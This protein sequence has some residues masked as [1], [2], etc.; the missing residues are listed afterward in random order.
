MISVGKHLRA[1]VGKVALG[2]LRET[3]G[4]SCFG[5]I[6]ALGIGL[7]AYVTVAFQ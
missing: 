6:R 3:A 4:W 1:Y 2:V 5:M 7:S